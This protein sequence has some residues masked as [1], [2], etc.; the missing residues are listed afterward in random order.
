[1]PAV[2]R[3]IKDRKCGRAAAATGLAAGAIRFMKSINNFYLFIINDDLPGGGRHPP[4]DFVSSW[5][6]ASHL[7]DIQCLDRP[8]GSGQAPKAGPGA[9]RCVGGC[10]TANRATSPTD[11][12]VAAARRP[13][14]QRQERAPDHMAAITLARCTRTSR[15]GIRGGRQRVGNC[16]RV[17]VDCVW[18][19]ATPKRG[20]KPGR[21]ISRIPKVNNNYT[22]RVSGSMAQPGRAPDS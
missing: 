13:G 21:A 11:F 3:R 16:R 14:G 20:R 22:R 15:G 7:D 5:E 2:R 19:R 1:M 4:G 17:T 8:A 9:N 18:L 12:P 6:V 10:G